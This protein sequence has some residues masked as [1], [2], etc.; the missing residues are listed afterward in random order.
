M[1]PRPEKTGNSFSSKALHRW[2]K[3]V[4]DYVC[5]ES[6]DDEDVIVIAPLSD[7]TLMQVDKIQSTDPDLIVVSGTDDKGKVAAIMS[8]NNMQIIFRI[9][10]KDV[11]RPRKPLGFDILKK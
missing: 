4:Y 10:K 7:G 8:H 11:E 3:K 1:N 9:V 2:I 6:Q 5:A